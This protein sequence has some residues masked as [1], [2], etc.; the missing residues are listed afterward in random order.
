MHIADEMDHEA[1]CIRALGRAGFTVTEIANLTLKCRHHAIATA[2]IALRVVVAIAALEIQV[3]P[4]TG[5]PPLRFAADLVRPSAGF[6]HGIAGAVTEQAFDFGPRFRCQFAR[7]NFRDD[8]VS[9]WSP[10]VCRS[11]EQQRRGESEPTPV[12]PSRLRN[13][14][15]FFSCTCMRCVNRSALGWS[16]ASF[17]IGNTE[18]AVRATAS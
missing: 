1:K 5:M 4:A 10:G 6:A 7:G 11:A 14:Q 17:T 15:A 2:A 13:I 8:L 9:V 18:R 3:M 12:Q 16:L